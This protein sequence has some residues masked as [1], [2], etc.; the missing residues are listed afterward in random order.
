MEYLAARS[1]EILERSSQVVP[2]HLRLKRLKGPVNGV[3]LCDYETPNFK[4]SAG[5]SVLVLSNSASYPAE[6]SQT[7]ESQTESRSEL[8]TGTTTSEDINDHDPRLIDGMTTGPAVYRPPIPF[9]W[10]RREDQTSG[11]ESATYTS[12]SYLT[13]SSIQGPSADKL[14]WHVRK[15]DGS[16]DGRVPAVCVWIPAPDLEARERSIA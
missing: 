2:I 15:P 12:T 5:D 10:E 1:K 9:R 8:V 6:Q 16:V 14:Q 11:T 4:L 3:M 13:E 7:S